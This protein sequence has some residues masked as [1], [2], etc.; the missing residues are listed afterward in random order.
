MEENVIEIKN[1]IMINLDVSVKNI[2]YV[3]NILFGILVYVFMKMVNTQ[4]IILIMIMIID[5]NYRRGSY[6]VQ[7]RNRNYSN[8]FY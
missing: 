7:R 3:K 6:I 5:N 2:I 4:Q 8:E 1:G